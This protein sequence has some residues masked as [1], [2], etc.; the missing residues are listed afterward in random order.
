[1]LKLVEGAAGVVG[2]GSTSWDGAGVRPL[3][4]SVPS[5]SQEATMTLW[6]E[7]Q[8][9]ATTLTAPGKKWFLVFVKPAMSASGKFKHLAW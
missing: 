2:H 4:F 8:F 7:E 3:P 9:H 6:L 5:L 1:M